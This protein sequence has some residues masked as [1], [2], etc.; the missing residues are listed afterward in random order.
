MAQF[1]I[2]DTPVLTLRQQ[3]PYMAV[4]QSDRLQ[5]ASE[6]IVA[7]LVPAQ[8]STLTP[9]LLNVPVWI[10][11]GREKH[12]YLLLLMAMTTVSAESLSRPVAS[13][14]NSR[15]AIIRSLELLL[16]R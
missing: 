13:I 2:Y 12:A 4:L 6:R 15:E 14:A 5:K 7:P 16:L 1:D 10:E 9:G 3:F 8:G 11:E